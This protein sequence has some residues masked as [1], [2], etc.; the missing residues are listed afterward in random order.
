MEVLIAT[1]CARVL[2][3][4]EHLTTHLSCHSISAE[5]TNRI[6]AF[7]FIHFVKVHGHFSTFWRN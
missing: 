7:N 5:L 6:Y 4:F 3:A 1:A 2:E